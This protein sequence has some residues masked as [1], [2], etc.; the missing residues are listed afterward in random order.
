MSAEA[1]ANFSEGNTYFDHAASHYDDLVSRGSR[2]LDICPLAVI[3]YSRI[4]THRKTHTSS[5]A[6]LSTP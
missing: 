5:H 3:L 6:L 1:N 4:H 2:T